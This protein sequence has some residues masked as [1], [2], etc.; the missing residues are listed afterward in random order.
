MV[1]TTDATIRLGQSR[2]ALAVAQL[3]A[4]SWRRHYRG[5]YSDRYLDGDLDGD[6]LAAWTDRLGQPSDDQFTLVVEQEGALIGFSHTTLDEDAVWGALLEN[7]HVRH[8]GHRRG[9]G[10]RL[11]RAT[12]QTLIERRP[13]AQMYLWVLA[14]NT[15]AQPFYRANGGVLGDREPAAAPQGDPRNLVGQPTKIRV[16]WADP[17]VLVKSGG[18]LA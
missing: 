17:A 9:V 2:D 8:D 3:H 7:L 1:T 13:R 16:A 11:L 10:T 12:A 5:A 18:S 15:G 4:D 6:R 14:Q